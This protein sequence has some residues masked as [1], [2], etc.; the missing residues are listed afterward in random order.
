[1]EFKLHEL[2]SKKD[3]DS[4]LYSAQDYTFLQSWE[5]GEMK[6]DSGNI[7]KRFVVTDSAEGSEKELLLLQIILVKAKRGNIMQ[8]RHAPV[9]LQDLSELSDKNINHLF[10]FLFS[11]LKNI[12]KDKNLDFIRIQPK[13][14]LQSRYYEIFKKSLDE[15]NFVSSSAHNID[16]EKTLVLDLKDKSEDV[17]MENMRKQTRYYIRRAQRDGVLIERTNDISRIKDFFEIHH[18]TTVRQNFTS[19][20]LEYY[21]NFFKFLN[22][23]SNSKLKAELFFAYSPDNYTHPDGKEAGGI[24]FSSAIIIYMGSKA[25]YSDGGSLSSFSKLPGS[26]LIQWEAVK[27]AIELGC[28]TYDF[29]GGVTPTN[30]GRNYPW[31]GIDLFKRGF[32]GKRIENIHAHDLGLSLKFHL[33]RL[34]EK[35]EK[36]KRGY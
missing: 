33:I 25:F 35:Y 16:A 19:Y 15:F 10:L 2:S 29:W 34:W 36:A 28:E 6:I 12:A 30:K 26:Y 1:M 17:I 4:L 32:G 11:E 9:T 22:S 31:A 5:F 27:R 3:Y 24:P 20:S 23:D 13:F 18:D 7:V 21:E 14:E 8:L